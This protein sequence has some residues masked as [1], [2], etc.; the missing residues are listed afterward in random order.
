MLL[1]EVMVEASQVTGMMPGFEAASG[2]AQKI[3]SEAAVVA[4]QENEGEVP[5]AA[6]TEGS[7]RGGDYTGQIDAA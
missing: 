2:E 7:G 4:K 1:D 5:G 3:L 6:S